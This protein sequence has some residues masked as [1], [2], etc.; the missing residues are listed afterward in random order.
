MKSG[1]ECLLLYPPVD[2]TKRPQAF[3]FFQRCTDLF[4]DDWDAHN[5]QRAKRLV[6][7]VLSPYL[8]SRTKKEKAWPIR[9]L[10]LDS[11]DGR[12]LST[13]LKKLAATVDGEQARFEAT[14]V[15]VLDIHPERAFQADSIRP[16]VSRID[17]YRS[18]FKRW[19]SGSSPQT[20]YDVAFLFKLL[21]NESLFEFE[22]GNRDRAEPLCEYYT[23]MHRLSTS[24][25]VVPK[26]EEKT[27]TRRVFN[28]KCL[29]Y[30]TQSLIAALMNLTRVALIEDADLGAQDLQAH[31][32]KHRLWNVDIFDLSKDLRLRKNHLYWLA[33]SGKSLPPM[34][35]RLWPR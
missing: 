34:G 14:L 25:G 9:F 18:D 33:Q 17:Y 15:D 12:F 35:Q 24:D 29:E 6:E 28:P 8:L 23:L 10:D 2:R 19:L 4:L 20:S 26:R 3:H 27:L 31:A 11:E 32:E 21:H 5:K 7:K 30:S 1:D 13:I 16:Y 22:L